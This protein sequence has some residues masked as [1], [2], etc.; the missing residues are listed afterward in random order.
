MWVLLRL[1][2]FFKEGRDTGVQGRGGVEESKLEIHSGSGSSKYS[3]FRIPSLT[4]ASN[5][6][7]ISA[8]PNNLFLIPVPSENGWLRGSEL[9]LRVRIL[10]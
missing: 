5:F 2:S 4:A 6:F 8:P 10:V 9:R 3:F 7:Y 1:Q